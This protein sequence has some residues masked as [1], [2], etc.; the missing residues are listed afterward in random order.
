[1]EIK[2]ALCRPQES[3]KDAAGCSSAGHQ[4]SGGD[5]HIGFV[6]ALGKG[7]IGRHAAAGQTTCLAVCLQLDISFP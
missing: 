5:I 6:A 1:M 4:G 3:Q 7:G 2:D